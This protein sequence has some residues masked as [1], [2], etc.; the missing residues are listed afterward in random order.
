VTEEITRA[1]LYI[2]V[3][4]DEQAESGYSIADQ[5]RDLMAH[6]RKE[7]YTEVDTIVDD[8]YSGAV[9]MRPG[10]TRI[11]ELAASG[12]IDLVLAKKRDRLFRDRYWRLSYERDL[13]DKGVSLVALDDTGNR[14]GD[15]IVDEFADWLREEVTK[16]IVAGRIEKAKQGKLIAAYKPIYGFNFTP[17]REGYVVVEHKMAVVRMVIETIASGGSIRGT[18]RMLERERIPA[19]GGGMIWREKTIRDMV[20]NDAYHPHPYEELVPMLTAEA[21]SKLNPHEEYRVV[22]YPQKKVTRLDPDPARG[23]K[24]PRIESRPER[25]EQ[26]PIPVA[27][28]GIPSEVIDAAR[29]A[30][31]DNVRMRNTGERVY[32]LLGLI[33][34]SVCGYLMTKNQRAGKNKTYH[35]YRCSN[36]QRYG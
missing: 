21:R 8:G 9:G 35:Y 16:N 3:S 14:F 10:L 2:R 18:K 24:R 33:R 6:A 27:S 30:I 36:H 31:K 23:Y 32:Q 28:S 12:E 15:A 20:N 11:M 7:G 1:A 25:G 5:K 26:V 29:R 13:A 4:T 34:C 22:W 17:D 19:P